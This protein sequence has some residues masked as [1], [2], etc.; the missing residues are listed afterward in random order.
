MISRHPGNQMSRTG[1]TMHAAPRPAAPDYG[2]IFNHDGTFHGLSEC[3]QQVDDFLA[4]VIEP[5]RAK[6]GPIGELNED[7]RV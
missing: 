3:P 5:I 7:L 2:I 1:N 4:E 6:Y